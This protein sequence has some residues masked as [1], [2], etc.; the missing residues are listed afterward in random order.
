[1]LAKAE[2]ELIS[3]GMTTRTVEHR[4]EE[5]NRATDVGNTFGI[6][7]CWRVSDPVRADNI[8]IEAL[9][10]SGCSRRQLPSPERR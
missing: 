7:R 8:V 9:S 3:A 1:M 5:I 6:Y 10:K 2:S 4:L